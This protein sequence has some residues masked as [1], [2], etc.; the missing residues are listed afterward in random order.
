MALLFSAVTVTAGND[1]IKLLVGGIPQEYDDLEGWS[2]FDN[3]MDLIYEETDVAVHAEV[4]LY[5]EG[6]SIKATPE[7]I[8]YF[9]KRMADDEN[10]LTDH[11][12]NIEDTDFNI[13]WS[14]EE[15]YGMEME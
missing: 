7:E 4:Y 5:G 2:D 15:L 8:A 14:P 3:F 1:E 13:R 11:C 6:E 12:D 9:M 10:F